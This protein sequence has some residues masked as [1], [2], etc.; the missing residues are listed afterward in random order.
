MAPLS[1]FPKQ[2][3][4]RNAQKRH[5]KE[6]TDCDSLVQSLRELN[7]ELL[8]KLKASETR[9]IETEAAKTA[10]VT[11]LKQSERKREQLQN[12]V[13]KVLREK[14]ELEEARE[15][16]WERLERMET[17]QVADMHVVE[18]VCSESKLPLQCSGCTPDE[19]GMSTVS[20]CTRA[21]LQ[22][23]KGARTRNANSIVADC[24]I[25]MED[26]LEYSGVDR[27][28]QHESHNAQHPP[29]VPSATTV[30]GQ[31][32]EWVWRWGTRLVTSLLSF[33][34]PR[35]IEEGESVPLLDA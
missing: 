6:R 11:T 33:F 16:L 13:E 1:R 17:A 8:I 14:R 24:I 19:E 25:Q 34:S 35:Q 21:S 22:T 5:T 15:K 7:K 4:G 9:A 30:F 2:K 27:N 20:F 23:L 28:A 31:F 10:A 12:C 32:F 29:D 18:R 3:R 26:D